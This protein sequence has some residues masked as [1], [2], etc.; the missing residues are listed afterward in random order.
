MK[1]I[2][3]VIKPCNER[4]KE[5]IERG[6]S[7][8]DEVLYFNDE[9]EMLNSDRKD[10]I[11]FIFGEPSAAAANKLPNLRVIQ[12]T[13]AGVNIYTGSVK[14][15]DGVKVLN[16]SG[17]FGEMISEYIV[18]GIVSLYRQFP[19]YSSQVKNNGWEMISGVDSIE[20]KRALI[21]GAGNIGMQT[22]RKLKAFDAVTVGITRT[23]HDSIEY[24]DEVYT[25]DN[26]DKELSK[27]DIV[28]IALPGTE[29]TKKLFN[30]ERINRIKPGATFVNVGRGFIVDTDALV[31]A[32]NNGIIKDA[33]I[34][35]VDPEPLPDNHP[36]RNMENVLLTPHISGISWGD[37]RLIRD[38]I[39]NMFTDNLRRDR[40]GEA[41]VN[42]VDLNLGY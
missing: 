32:L 1:R 5:L 42:E 10:D 23:K 2:I 21:V 22:A 16:A 20:A 39:I 30:R 14:L 26:L 38:K 12:L 31:E 27:A 11:E 28:V 4:D 18:G 34:D 40:A 29:D 19:Q 3:A 9:N 15:K 33:V 24:F 8:D 25:I 35:V 7:S 13:W 6:L 41:L 17:A 37:N 36:L